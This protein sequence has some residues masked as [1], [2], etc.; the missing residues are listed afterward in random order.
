MAQHTKDPPDPADVAR[1]RDA[2]RDMGQRHPATILP[3]LTLF[4]EEAIQRATSP[5]DAG[6]ARRQ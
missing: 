5:P 6:E 1:Q 4:C 2:L 3:R